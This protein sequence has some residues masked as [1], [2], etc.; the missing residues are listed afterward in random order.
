[1]SNDAQGTI[2]ILVVDDEEIIADLICTGLRYEGFSVAMATSGPDALEQAGQFKPHLVVLD[3]M[4]PGIDGL[5]V[6]RR[7]RKQSD[8]AILMLTAKGE[9]D[10]RVEGLESGA[11]DYLVKPF[12]FKELLARI[13]AILRRHQLSLRRRLSSG[14]LRLDCE[15]R[16]V[17]RADQPID[18]TPREF[19]ILAVLIGHPRQV[20][21]REM[22]LEQVWGY[23]VLTDPNLIEVHISALREKLGDKARQLIRTVRGV[24]YTLR[25]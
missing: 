11:D 18:L 25:G 14:D 16:E 10:E 7:L 21:T 22:L 15:T 9:L 1:M 2:R 20:F 3:W 12:K 17:W 19:E 24:G 5:E 8:V 6:C 23:D 4:L 13:R